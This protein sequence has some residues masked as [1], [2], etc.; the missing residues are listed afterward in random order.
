VA[1][2]G[3][4]RSRGG[5]PPARSRKPVYVPVHTPILRRRG[6]WIGVL[7][8][9][10]VGSAA[11]IA[12]GL[13][14]EASTRRADA[15]DAR[16][17]TAMGTYQSKV[18]PI[19]AGVGTANP[20]VSFSALPDLHSAV[21][22]L[23]KGTV[24][25]SD[26]ASKA[27]SAANQARTAADDLGKIDVPT[28]VGGKGFTVEFVNYAINSKTR[29][30]EA[31]DLY[32]RVASLLETASTIQGEARTSVLDAASGIL[33]TADKVMND[34]YNDYVQA[35]IAAKTY[36]PSLPNP[37]ATGATGGGSG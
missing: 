14:K 30:V 20:P 27:R 4:T 32:Q 34:G 17:A 3:K 7:V 11:G 28:L 33:A 8:V 1:I 2:M 13:A 10:V 37:P 31:V 24:T 15:L 6:F 25:P 36:V 9:V 12:Y 19:L 18:D 5:R 22:G 23:K 29:L 26:A 35:Q 21:D 16:L